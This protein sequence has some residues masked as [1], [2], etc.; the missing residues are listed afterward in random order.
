MGHGEGD[1]FVVESNGYDERSWLSADGDLY[2]FPHSADMRVVERYKRLDY[3]KLQGSLT[4]IDPKVYTKP[5]T[6]SGVAML[7]PNAE[8]GEYMCVTSDSINF[9]ERQTIPSVGLS[10]K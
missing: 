7:V 3:G 1:E 6:T 5:W 10:A 8:L 2:G 4:V 9:N